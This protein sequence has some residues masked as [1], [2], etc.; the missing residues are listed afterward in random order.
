MISFSPQRTRRMPG[1]SAQASPPAMPRQSRHEPHHR[2]RHLPGDGGRGDPGQQ[3]ADHEL[4][5]DTDVPDAGAQRDHE[6][7]ADDQQ[8]RHVDEGLVIRMTCPGRG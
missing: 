8:R 2:V 4:A 1:T 7:R 3:R 5:I 6:P